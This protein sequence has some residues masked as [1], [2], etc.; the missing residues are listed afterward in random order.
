MLPYVSY[1]YYPG[2][3]VYICADATSVRQARIECYIITVTAETS[4]VAY[5]LEGD[6][7]LYEESSL[8]IT[9]NE[10]FKWLKSPA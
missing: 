3:E 9:P 4:T 2:N 10:A 5:K 1:S 6:E 7:V 8:H